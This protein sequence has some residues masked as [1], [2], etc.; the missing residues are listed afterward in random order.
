MIS[1]RSFF[2]VFFRCT[3][4]VRKLKYKNLLTHHINKKLYFTS[5]TILLFH[6]KNGALVRSVQKCIHTSLKE[7][8][9]KQLEPPLHLYNNSVI[10]VESFPG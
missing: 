5:T 10:Y 2:V 6:I 1:I 4:D 8:D 9:I 3:M 7:Y